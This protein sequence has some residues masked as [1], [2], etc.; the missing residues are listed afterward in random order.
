MNHL[1]ISIYFLFNSIQNFKKKLPQQAASY[2]HKLHFYEI[3]TTKLNILR[4]I[5]LV[6]IFL[7][8]FKTLLPDYLKVT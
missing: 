8:F 1:R 7:L 3:K 2:Q 6:L 5:I 4:F